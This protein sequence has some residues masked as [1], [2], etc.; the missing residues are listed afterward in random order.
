MTVRGVGAVAKALGPEIEALDLR[1]DW[2]G[3][4]YGDPTAASMAEV[5]RAAAS[6]VEIE[7][8]YTGK[9]LAA[10]R[11]T[12]IPGSTTLWLNTHGP[13]D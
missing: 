10:I 3:A 1:G 11:D 4:C 12:S 7:P 8:V 2:L 13:R 5:E 6:G 9:A